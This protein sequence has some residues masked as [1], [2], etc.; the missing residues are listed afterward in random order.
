MAGS[1]GF[2]FGGNIRGCNI[3]VPSAGVGVLFNRSGGVRVEG[4]N[5]TIPSGA[6]GISF[7]ASSSNNIADGVTASGGTAISDASYLN[8]PTFKYPSAAASGSTLNASTKYQHVTGTTTIS[9]IS[10]GSMFPWDG[11]SIF[12]MTLVF[13]SACAVTTGG[14]ISRAA[15][16]AAGQA[17]LF[18]YDPGTS[19]WYF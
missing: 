1:H 2:V 13:E 17:V 12:T 14:N 3:S 5:W 18:S 11:A 6:T 9:T 10:N 15:S 4:C 19:L 8:T 16:F 7:T